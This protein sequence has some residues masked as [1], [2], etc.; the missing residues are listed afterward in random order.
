M[1]KLPTDMEILPPSDDRIFKTLLTHP[2]AKRVLINVV[3]AVLER[4]VIN[5]QIR[6]TEPPVMDV[7]EKAERFD[8]MAGHCPRQYNK[9]PFQ[10]RYPAALQQGSSC[11]LRH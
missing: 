2:N 7:D 5:V 9:F 6:N 11:K 3:T 8:W 1:A 4:T 10:R